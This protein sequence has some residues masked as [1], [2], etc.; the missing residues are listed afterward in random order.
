MNEGYKEKEK[1]ETMAI[2]RLNEILKIK[3]GP[4]PR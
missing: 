2:R 3:K 4:H 1:K